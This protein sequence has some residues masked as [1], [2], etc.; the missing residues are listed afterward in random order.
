VKTENKKKSAFEQKKSAVVRNAI[1]RQKKIYIIRMQTI[2]LPSPAGFFYFCSR[3]KNSSSPA[4]AL[5]R[6][7]R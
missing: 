3:N 5:A 1:L 4:L 6:D 2:S 7:G